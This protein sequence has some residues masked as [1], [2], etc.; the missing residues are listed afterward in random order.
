MLDTSV[1]N[2]LDRA[3]ALA[4]EVTTL[5]RRGEVGYTDIERLEVLRSARH[6][7]HYRRLAVMFTALTKVVLTE[8]AILRAGQVQEQL[9]QRGHHRGVKI[10]DLLIAAAAEE[11]GVRVLHYDHD[12]DLISSITGQNTAWVVEKGSVS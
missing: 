10:P 3:P 11:A 5:F 7:E 2:R 12:Y 1:W 4:A 6:I 9:V 8:A